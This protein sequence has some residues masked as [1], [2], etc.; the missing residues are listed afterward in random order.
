MPN[1]NKDLCISICTYVQWTDM[2]KKISDNL[3]SPCYV[4]QIPL[5]MLDN[6]KEH[7]FSLIH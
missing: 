3:H 1:F 2:K 6:D 4:P 5:L 7:T